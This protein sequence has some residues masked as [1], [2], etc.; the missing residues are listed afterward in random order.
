MHAFECWFAVFA[1]LMAPHQ[2]TCALA[3]AAAVTITHPTTRGFRIAVPQ[4]LVGAYFH[5]RFEDPVRFE[6]RWDLRLKI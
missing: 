3:A 1:P 6:S 4:S 2:A 5:L